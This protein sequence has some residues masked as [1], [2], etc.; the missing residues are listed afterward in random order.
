M[1]FRTA[2]E[3]IIV[4]TDQDKKT[5][6]LVIHWTGGAHTQLAM[7]RPRPATETGT[8]TEALEIE[9]ELCLIQRELV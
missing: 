9:D 6:E 5:L 2:I 8:P 3:H 7:G 1:I 4:R